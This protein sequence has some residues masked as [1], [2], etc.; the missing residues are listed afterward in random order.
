MGDP[1]GEAPGRPSTGQAQ[2]Q[3]QAEAA[4]RRDRSR[5]VG[6]LRRRAPYIGDHWGDA[7]LAGR[8]LLISSSATLGLTGAVRFL[9]NSL[10]GPGAE[11]AGGAAVNR[12]FEIL[13]GVAVLLALATAGRY[14]F[15]T[16]LGERV[17][18]DLRK[19]VYKHI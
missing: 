8:F 16:K 17:T 18:A 12:W 4:A 3:T 13:G 11:A 2:A 15:I 10:P 6:A 1:A 19:A 7:S 5:N 14:F 9:I